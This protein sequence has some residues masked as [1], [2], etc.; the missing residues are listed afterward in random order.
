MNKVIETINQRMSLRK[1]EEKNISKEHLDIILNS[2]IK[3]PTAGN[4]MM[5]TILKIE[6][7]KTKERLSITCDN[8]PFIKNAPVVLI[9]LA[10]LQK[11]YEY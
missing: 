11:W 7:R 10:D 6:D 1:Y 3:A 4:M 5:Y 8:Q 9:F 2:A